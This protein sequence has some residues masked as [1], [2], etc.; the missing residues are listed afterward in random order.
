ME[1]DEQSLIRL[2]AELM[3]A[4]ESCALGVF[5]YVVPEKQQ[6]AT[7]MTKE[8][9]EGLEECQ[10]LES[11][12]AKTSGTIRQRQP[13]TTGLPQLPVTVTGAILS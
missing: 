3:E 8:R 12:S 1:M 6:I 5:M 9:L 13:V 2:Y 10:R 11:Q 7:T 4:S